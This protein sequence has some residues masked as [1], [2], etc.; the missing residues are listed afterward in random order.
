MKITNLLLSSVLLFT[1]YSFGAG[2]TCEIDGEDGY[3]TVKSGELQTKIDLFVKAGIKSTSHASGL[4]EVYNNMAWVVPDNLLYKKVD[5]VHA[6]NA[7][8]PIELCAISETD[9][10]PWTSFSCRISLKSTG[11]AFIPEVTFQYKDKSA[12]SYSAKTAVRYQEISSN[13]SKAEWF[14][15]ASKAR[16]T[17]AS[18]PNLYSQMDTYKLKNCKLL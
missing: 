2:F 17:N 9:T 7:Y 8:A 3:F 6:V 10:T 13:N 18:L 15:K 1:S 12:F 11:P 16:Q 14:I 5:S 4:P